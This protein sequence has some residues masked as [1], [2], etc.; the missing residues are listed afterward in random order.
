MKLDHK[1]NEKGFHPEKAIA[2][3]LKGEKDNLTIGIDPRIISIV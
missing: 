3:I 2:E 1:N